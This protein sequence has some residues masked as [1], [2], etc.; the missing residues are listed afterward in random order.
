M[1]IL[2]RSKMAT[3]KRDETNQES[4]S[5]GQSGR[6]VERLTMEYRAVINVTNECRTRNWLLEGS[7]ASVA[8][9]VGDIT[10]KG[11]PVRRQFSVHSMPNHYVGFCFD[12]RQAFLLADD[13]Q[14]TCAQIQERHLAKWQYDK[15]LS[16][17]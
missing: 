1:T 15:N 5:A 2:R 7:L 14:E 4:S 12:G 16:G 9:A 11:G 13:W 8:L 3:M 10:K 17:P 6:L